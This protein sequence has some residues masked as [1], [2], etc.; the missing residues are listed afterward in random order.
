MLEAFIYFI[1]IPDLLDVLVGFLLLVEEAVAM[2][3]SESEHVVGADHI[4]SCPIR[5]LN[6]NLPVHRQVSSQT[7]EN[8]MS[9]VARSL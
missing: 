4:S 1:G 3:A 5:S 6:Q 7:Y 8:D 9:G 2:L